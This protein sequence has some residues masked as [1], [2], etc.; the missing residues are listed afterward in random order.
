MDNFILH[1]SKK[2]KDFWATF[3]IVAGFLTKVFGIVG[4]CF[5]FFQSI[6]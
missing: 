5:I 3:F 4:I 6:N 2:E 1:F